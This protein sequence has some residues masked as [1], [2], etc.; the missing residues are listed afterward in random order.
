MGDSAY[1]V[2]NFGV[3]IDALLSG[4]FARYVSANQHAHCQEIY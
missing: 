4:Q 3:V 1:S 2:T